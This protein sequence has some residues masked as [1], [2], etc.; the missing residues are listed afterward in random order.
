MKTAIAI[1][2]LSL[3]QVGF[4]AVTYCHKPTGG[5][6]AYYFLWMLV[7]AT[8]AAIAF[9]PRYHFSAAISNAIIAGLMFDYLFLKLGYFWPGRP[10][11]SP[12]LA[13]GYVVMGAVLAFVVAGFVHAI[14]AAIDRQPASSKMSQEFLAFGK[15]FSFSTVCGAVAFPLLLMSGNVTVGRPTEP[16]FLFAFIVV[17]C[18][19]LFGS[20]LGL[21]VGLM[22]RPTGRGI[23]IAG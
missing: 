1:F 8:L 16:P 20:A 17:V 23:A 13:I 2:M 10:K 7:P 9:A 4:F 5:F 22:H 6:A 15:G 19:I 3:L 14:I 12:F 18:M 21:A 11:E